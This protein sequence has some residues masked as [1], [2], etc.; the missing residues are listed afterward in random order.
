MATG[1]EELFLGDPSFDFGAAVTVIP[2]VA[3]ILATAFAS[4]FF[5]SSTLGGGFLTDSVMESERCIILLS[6]LELELPSGAPPCKE[7]MYLKKKY[8]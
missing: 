7:Y 5:G 8:I 6:T 2:L 4:D 1:G 3:K